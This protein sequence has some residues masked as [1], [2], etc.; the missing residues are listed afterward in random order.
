M[1]E[2][3]IHEIAK[4]EGE[5]PLF[6][7]W[8]ITRN[9]PVKSVQTAHDRTWPGTNLLWGLSTPSHAPVPESFGLFISVK[10]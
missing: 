1:M 6:Q 3:C 9:L 7:E 10:M 5:E 4:I 2:E 8:T